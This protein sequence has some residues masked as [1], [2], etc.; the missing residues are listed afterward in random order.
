MFLIDTDVQHYRLFLHVPPSYQ[1]IVVDGKEYI[2]E[3]TPPPADHEPIPTSTGYITT[4][5]AATVASIGGI[6]V[7]IVF[8]VC[9]WC[10]SIYW[11]K[12]KKRTKNNSGNKGSKPTDAMP[13]RGSLMPL[14]T[15]TQ[16]KVTS[17]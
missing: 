1:Q 14:H 3:P 13:M 17:V 16:V 5:I 10:A 15:I 8:I 2:A 11:K 4:I 9:L 6:L 12:N 7:S